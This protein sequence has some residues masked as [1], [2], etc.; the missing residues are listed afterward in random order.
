MDNKANTPVVSCNALTTTVLLRHPRPVLP[1]GGICYGRL[2]LELQAGWQADVDALALPRLAGAI[3]WSSPSRRCADPAHR[4]A[5]RLGLEV[6]HDA[7]LRELDFGAWEGLAWDRVPRE[8]LDQWAAD[9][10]GFAPPAGESGAALIERVRQFHT[11]L[12]EVARSAIVVS[13]G[14]PL[15]VLSPLLRGV[16]VDLAASSMS[17]LEMRWHPLHA[18]EQDQ[19]PPVLPKSLF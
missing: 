16:A 4:L 10:L 7:R 11:M 5:A 13:H 2:D 15:K 18:P 3:V 19:A 9:L 6:R 1:P 12:R 8:A 14:G 17:F